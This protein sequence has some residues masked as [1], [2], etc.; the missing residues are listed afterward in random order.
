MLG[1]KPLAAG[2]LAS[3]PLGQPTGN[4]SLP[5]GTSRRYVAKEPFPGYVVPDTIIPQRKPARPI[6]DR[7]NDGAV[8]EQHTPAPS[9][10]RRPMMPPASLFSQPRSG[11]NVNGLPTFNHLVPPNMVEYA[12]KMQEA[13]DVSDVLAALQAFSQRQ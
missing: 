10:P 1:F 6:W 8:I 2:P 7:A 4:M 5:G 12:R 9:A 13:Q 11:I 3:G